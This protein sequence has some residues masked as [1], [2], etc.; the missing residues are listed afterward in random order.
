MAPEE[1]HDFLSWERGRLRGKMMMGALIIFFGVVF[2]LRELG[3][4]IPRTIFH[5]STFIIAIGLIILVKHKFR[6][7]M[8]YLL[9]GIGLSLKL[10]FFFPEMINPKVVISIFVIIFGLI[11]VVKARNPNSNRP[12]KWERMRGSKGMM[13]LTDEEI[14]S[15]DF[16]DAVS[17][18]GGV[19]RMVTS[20][21]FKGAD[22]FTVFGGM[23]LNLLQA[24]FETKAIVDMTTVFGGTEIIVPADWQVRSEVVTIFGGLEDNR[25]QIPMDGEIQKVLVLKGTCIFGGVEIKSFSA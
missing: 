16:V 8:G 22:L 1:Q 17:V 11:M 21:K 19:K 24:D 12:N 14:S 25:S 6:R 7:V 15:E 13:G 5:P 20:K 9:V 3:F 10:H 4:H 23:E 2:L 18:F